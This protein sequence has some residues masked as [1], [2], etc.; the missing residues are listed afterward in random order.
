MKKN[1]DE[2]L[3]A[4]IEDYNKNG[5]ETVKTFY[6]IM[7]ELEIIDKM[8]ALK[9]HKI[10]MV[11]GLYCVLLDNG[12]KEPEVKEFLLEAIKDLEDFVKNN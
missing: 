12:K 2:T 3:E 9:V 6:G 7:E 4:L 5:F 11:G 10:F 8:K 1:S